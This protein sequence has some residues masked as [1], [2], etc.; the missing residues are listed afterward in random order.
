MLTE[1][2]KA[3]L[4]HLGYEWWMFCAAD[5]LLRPVPDKPDDPVR[6]ALIESLAMH[7]RN[8]AVFFFQPKHHSTD[9]SVTDLGR[10]LVTEKEPD[11]LKAWRIDANKLCA[12]L[13]EER[14]N[15]PKSWDASIV[16]P[17]IKERIDY[18]RKTLGPDMPPDWIGDLTTDSYLLNPS[19]P[20]PP[21]R[22]PASTGAVTGPGL[23]EISVS[24][25][26][27]FPQEPKWRR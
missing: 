11:Q 24:S 15:V 3:V 5:D 23:V 2:E 8:L 19:V 16:R 21:A 1:D 18:I 9:R 7:G 27:T 26:A 17:L 12:H 13:T 22:S 20:G 10:G 4:H 6:N 25:N 14:K